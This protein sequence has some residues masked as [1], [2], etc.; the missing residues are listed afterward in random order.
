[1][2]AGRTFS[3]RRVASSAYDASLVAG[4]PASPEALLWLATA[5][6]ARA[7]GLSESVGHL[8]P[9]YEGDIVAVDAPATADLP[10]LIDA[11]IFRHDAGP[12]RAAYVRGRR[13]RN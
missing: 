1:M 10:A 9:G 11:L 3:M 13:L 8:L 12:V 5:G 7:L 2:G 4:A 6:G